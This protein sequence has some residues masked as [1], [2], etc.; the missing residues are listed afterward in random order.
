VSE[1]DRHKS[2]GGPVVRHEQ[3]HISDGSP[4]KKIPMMAGV[5]GAMCL[6][7]A[8]FLY[9]GHGGHEGGGH[10]NRF[11]FS[12]LTAYMVFLAISLGGLFFVLI[13]HATRAGW[14]IVVRRLA[15]NVSI[16]LPLMGVLVLPILFMGRYDLF[17]WACV[18]VTP[19]EFEALVAAGS[20]HA[21]MET[22]AVLAAKEPYLNSPFF[23]Q[24]GL[25]FV[26]LWSVLALVYWRWSTQQ[27]TASD[28]KPLSHKMRWFAPFGLVLFALSLTFGAF[29]WLM[30]LDPHWFSTV[31]GVYYFAG[32]VI[33]IHAVLALVVIML[34][35]SGY[36]RG[37]VTK[38][39]FHDLGKMMFA[40]TVFW[41]YIGFSQYM[42]IWYASIPEETEWYAYRGH[43]SF[44][45]VSLVLVFA[46]FV[47][48]F[49]GLMSRHIKRNPRTLMFW[50]IWVLVA[51][52]IDMFWLVHPVHAHHVGSHHLGLDLG[53]LLTIVGVGGLWLAVF[54]WAVVNRPLV[55]LKDPR[56]E[57][58]VN[59][60]NF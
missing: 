9:G 13:Q 37:V 15:E 11:W 58:S 27:D 12:Y 35:R 25:G 28:P 60:E 55:P 21:P 46:R 41:A 40:F 3:V 17:H 22:D 29:D 48:P 7:L 19:Q 16:T 56:L 24:R 10:G 18:N 42:L 39:H 4:W 1:H 6:G 23:L 14:S 54:T 31:F 50:A 26:T 59:F 5:A 47:F 20:C 33:S 43:G 38:E 44:L 30:G 57:E 49:L 51:Q 34:H 2:K 52:L 53:D 45:T 8:F 36:L 32:A